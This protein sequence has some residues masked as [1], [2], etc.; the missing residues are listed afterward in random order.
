MELP[1]V[2]HEDS[3]ITVLGEMPGA[4]ALPAAE[5]LYQN[6]YYSV[7]PNSALVLERESTYIK[8]KTPISAQTAIQIAVSL[9]HL[10]QHSKETAS[11]LL[12][13]TAGLE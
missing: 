1:Y 10:L 13:E 2:L 8:H 6:V 7:A 9:V 11:K 4:S 12:V 5:T 3:S